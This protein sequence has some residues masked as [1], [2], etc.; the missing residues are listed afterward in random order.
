[1]PA[2][3][4]IFAREFFGV[5]LGL[6]P[7]RAL[8]AELGHPER[9][10]PTVI[11]A[12]TNGKGSVSA[13]TA[14]ALRAAGHRT[15]RYTSPH[16]TSI[17]ERFDLDGSP[18]PLDTIE[19][20][21]STVL[22]AEA[23]GRGTGTIPGPMTFFELTT[24]TAF[25]A[26]RQEGAEVA[27]IEVG[28]GGRLDATNVVSPVAGAIT[29]IDF[30]H[31][32]HLGTTLGQIAAEKAGV[33]RAGAPLV[34]GV[35]QDE[36]LGVIREAARAAGAPLVE[37]LREC[38]AEWALEGNGVTRLSLTTP[39]GRYGPLTLA[40][41]GAHQ[42]ANAMVAVRLLESLRLPPP[43][44]SA[45]APGP[46]G[47]GDLARVPQAAIREG[48]TDAAW[49][50]R[51]DLRAMTDGREVLLDAAH[52]PSGAASLVEYL[53]AAGLAPLPVVF[54]VMR[55]KA[56]AEMLATLA[57]AVSRFV[58]TEA[59]TARARAAAELPELAREA[60]LGTPWEVRERPADALDA[61]WHHARRICVCGSIFLVGDV[62]RTTGGLSPT[63]SRH[64]S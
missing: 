60:G 7:M 43:G 6:G 22:A 49:P 12:G 5:K 25:E 62:L 4:E 38:V 21:A 10:C 57:P 51:L 52:N 39:A 58:F 20:A 61:A 27:V 26:F 33:M 37:A 50:G 56:C 11:V 53:R 2:L 29:T 17:A 18:L 54:G 23:R 34:T 44:G 19:R 47:A 28:L 63:T 9:A 35:T 46:D 32:E 48:L 36:P 30:D 14:R 45:R 24:A 8:C 31:Q 59:A 1:M 15:A 42:V 16:L 64:Q 41:R 13:M 55:D 3:D 40:L